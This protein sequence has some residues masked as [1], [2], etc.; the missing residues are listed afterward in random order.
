MSKERSLQ[1]TLFM[2]MSVLVIAALMAVALPRPALAAVCEEYYTV[3]EGDSI[4][5]VAKKYETTINKIA[6]ANDME[7]PYTLETGEKLCI[8]KVPE[9]SSDYTWS[10]AYKGDTVTI[11]GEKFK[12]TYP[13][14]FKAR[15]DDTSP[16]YK[17]GRVGS[18]KQG[19]IDSKKFTLPKALKGE[20]FLTICLKDG[21]NDYLDCKRVIRQ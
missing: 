8:P 5:Q 3:K 11:T 9:K 2:V 15:V 16:W 4:G 19:E 10:A 13:F 17:L 6:K 1:K 18:D 12:K 14:I 20:T 7:R 21:V